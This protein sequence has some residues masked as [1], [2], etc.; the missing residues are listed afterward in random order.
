MKNLKQIEKQNKKLEAQR[1]KILTAQLPE[2]VLNSKNSIAFKNMK[3]VKENKQSLIFE[4][5]VGEQ[6][7]LQLTPHKNG[8]TKGPRVP[9]R[10]PV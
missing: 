1:E 10:R 9:V 7:L 6:Y 3:L 2:I 4:D 8:I 5:F